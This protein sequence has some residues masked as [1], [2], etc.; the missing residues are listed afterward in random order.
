MD[1]QDVKVVDEAAV[2]FNITGVISASGVFEPQLPTT[3]GMGTE[4]NG[5]DGP[6][7]DAGGVRQDM[8]EVEKGWAPDLQTPNQLTERLQPLWAA[9]RRFGIEQGGKSPTR[10][11]VLGELGQHGGDKMES[12]AVLAKSGRLLSNDDMEGVTVLRE[13]RHSSFG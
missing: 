7:H 6:S 1:F 4:G 11:R 2:G 8:D 13:M 5:G 9:C 10:R 3:L 12:T